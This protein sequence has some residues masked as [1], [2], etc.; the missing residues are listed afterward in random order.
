MRAEGGYVQ[1]RF[2]RKEQRKQT[3]QPAALVCYFVVTR[4]FLKFVNYLI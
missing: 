3:A 2:G 1:I 4:L